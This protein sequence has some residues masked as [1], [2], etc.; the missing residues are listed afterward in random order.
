MWI[1]EHFNSK[2]TI[3]GTFMEEDFDKRLH[4]K[5]PIQMQKEYKDE[6]KFPKS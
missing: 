3:F 4:I 5:H 1:L 2:K 6:T